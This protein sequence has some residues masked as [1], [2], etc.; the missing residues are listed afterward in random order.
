MKPW[1][2]IGPVVLAVGSL[3]AGLAVAADIDFCNA[4]AAAAT[5][6]SRVQPG[7]TPQREVAPMTGGATE[8]KPGTP[9]S[10]G[11]PV[12]PA[13]DASQPGSNPTGGRITDSSQPGMP[14]SDVGMAPIGQTDPRYRQAYMA[15]LSHQVK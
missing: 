8:V 4:K 6:P 13:P 12:Q 1:K 14:S 11:Q 10:P 3:A 2:L 5:K 7:S 9:A 15:C